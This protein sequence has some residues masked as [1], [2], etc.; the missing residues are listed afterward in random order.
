[1]IDTL[2]DR[3]KMIVEYQTEQ[4]RQNEFLEKIINCLAEGLLLLMKNK[5]FY[6]YLLKSGFG[7][8]KKAKIF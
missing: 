5:K 7:S 4:N 1:M 6:K 3:E 2:N 8:E